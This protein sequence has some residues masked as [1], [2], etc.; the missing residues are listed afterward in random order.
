MPSILSAYFFSTLNFEVRY[1]RRAKMLSVSVFATWSTSFVMLTISWY[2]TA[3][4]FSKFESYS[5]CV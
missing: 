3:L 5:F 2:F 4:N 1:F